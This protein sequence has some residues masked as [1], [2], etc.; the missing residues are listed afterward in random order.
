[1][2]VNKAYEY[3]LEYLRT[4]LPDNFL[5]VTESTQMDR[6]PF[7][8]VF[9]YY[10]K[11]P[12]AVVVI[13][14]G[15]LNKDDSTNLKDRVRHLMRKSDLPYSIV[16]TSNSWH[17]YQRGENGEVAELRGLEE[18]FSLIEKASNE[19]EKPFT[20]EEITS[21]VETMIELARKHDISEHT[22]G[23]LERL[24]I[25]S[26]RQQ[27]LMPQFELSCSLSMS[28]EQELFSS[29]VGDFTEDAL[30]RYTTL[31]TLYRILLDKKASM[32]SITCMNDKS[33]CYYVDKYLNEDYNIQIS[34][35]GNEEVAE[36]NQYFILSC[37]VCQLQD[38]L[39]M[40]RMY[41]DEAKGVC[42]KY[43]IDR[44]LVKGNFLLARVSYSHDD[45]THPE[46]DFIREIAQ[47]TIRGRRFK[48]RALPLWKHFF[49]PYTYK[50][51]QEVRLLFHEE[52]MKAYKWI[53]TSDNIVCP[54][55]EFDI[56][57][58]RT[59]PLVMNGIILGPKFPESD[60]N[61]SQLRLFKA[62]QSIE[63]DG[64]KSVSF[65]K[66]NNYR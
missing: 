5:L 64:D 2:D 10:K 59:F 32:C 36:L 20:D 30:C 33:E 46:L 50:E 40:W 3:Q 23:V 56:S 45:G 26:I 16:F 63:E 11:L 58:S 42:I 53:K 14:L 44:N 19:M 51:E 62:A 1:M 39:F 43:K 4:T 6:F 31:N 29:L 12:C 57:G 15:A 55:V 13:K 48:L 66:I 17:A 65:S 35:L 37:S 22:R 8:D 41:G 47:L 54:V 28:F 34:Q 18:F 21:F 38:S 24:E 27:F 25:E 49:K 60:T 52:N 61:A 7:A 9:L